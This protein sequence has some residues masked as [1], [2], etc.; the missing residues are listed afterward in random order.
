MAERW[1]PG[2]FRA[3]KLAGDMRAHFAVTICSDLQRSKES[4]ECIEHAMPS[5]AFRRLQEIFT[6][7]HLACNDA[8]RQR[9]NASRGYQLVTSELLSRPSDKK[10]SGA[11]ELVTPGTQ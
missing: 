7:L 8:Q 1:L 9:R 11:R 4:F 10:Y 5:N 3:D 6:Y 2:G